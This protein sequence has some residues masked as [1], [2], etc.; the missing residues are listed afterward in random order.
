VNRRNPLRVV[1]SGFAFRDKVAWSARKFPMGEVPPVTN[2]SPPPGLT[3][4]SV[5]FGSFEV[6]LRAGELRKSGMKIKLQGQPLE[7]LAL[8]LE[9]PGQVVTR[10]ELQQ[11]VWA[12]D[13]FV[14]FEHGLNKAIS[15]VREALADEADNPRFIETLPRRG[16]RF[17]APVEGMPRAIGGR[18]APVLPAKAVGFRIWHEWWRRTFLALLLL[19]GGVGLFYSAKRSVPVTSPSEYTQITNFTDSA[20]APSLSPD[21][22]MVTF[23]RSESAFASIGQIYVK[24]LPNGEPVRLTNDSD[25]K[26][27]PVFAPD[28]SR[29]AYTDFSFTQTPIGFNTWTVPVLGGQ[30]T[31]LL[32]NASGLT[33]ITDQRILF[34]EVK[35]GFH[36]GIVTATES[37]AD[38]REIYFPAN[39]HAMAHYA[40]ASPDGKSI[41]VVE[42]DQ[43]H[44]FHQPCRLVPFDGSSAGKQVGPR[45]TCT[46]AAWSPDGK[47]MYFG[48]M[49]GHDS[50]LWRQKFPDGAPEQ[51]TFGP[52]EEEGLAVAPDGRSLVTSVGTR[53]SAVWIHDESGERAISSEGYAVAPHLSRDG[54]RVFYLLAQDLV[55]EG[56][57]GWMN[58][59]GNLRS[60]DLDSG[61][62]DSVLPGMSVT[63]YDISRDEKE[64]AFT[65]TGS[66]G[67][68]TIWLAALDR[69]TPPRQIAR[70][71]DEVSFG[72]DGD[73]VFRSLEEE[74]Q[75][76]VRIKRDGTQREKITTVPVLDK[77]AVSPDSEWVIVYSF[78]DG[79]PAMLAVP[80]HGGAAKK[81]CAPGCRS[82]W[83]SDGRF[84]Y[85]AIPGQKTVVI[86]VPAGKS[87]PDLPTSGIDSTTNAA[88]LPDA[89]QI[90]HGFIAPG[91]NPSEYIFLKTDLQRNL[92]R[93]PLH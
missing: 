90:E 7:V 60:V 35:T 71:G 67:E 12:T 81:I 66:S 23:K 72:A 78:D 21:G 11:K 93:I 30:P 41:L 75:G 26:Y 88:E 74:T 56:G 1:R 80:L 33:W 22:R 61:K 58:S 31:L 86:P 83:S 77:L 89:S 42:M 57:I 82:A 16:Y 46:S 4:A 17:I 73:L 84:F 13:T 34:S 76:L 18:S 59:S 27:A 79:G 85:V 65:T 48:V 64:V 32:P 14:D 40:Y 39:E 24:L 25:F 70:V 54:R 8:L 43:T 19:A 3:N 92:F 6:D 45:G 28:G 51:I 87:L 29:V 20:V 69:R 38:R 50:H 55:L 10:E 49:I 47:W 44:A 63:D 2:G 37:R 15:R 52:S 53:R 68:K 5:R 62:T 9:R 91:P 36:M